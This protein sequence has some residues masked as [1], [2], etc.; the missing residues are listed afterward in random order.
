MI[1]L[2]DLIH[3][4]LNTDIWVNNIWMKFIDLHN[5]KI[6]TFEN[7]LY[8]LQNIYSLIKVFNKFKFYKKKYD[9]KMIPFVKH[10]IKNINNK[11][12]YENNNKV[13]NYRDQ[14]THAFYPSALLLIYKNYNNLINDSLFYNKIIDVYDNYVHKYL[15]KKITL[16]NLNI[17][18]HCHFILSSNEL[19]NYTNDDKYLNMSIK[20]A[21]D[22]INYSININ[23]NEVICYEKNK[24]TSFHYYC[25]V[26]QSF[27]D[28]Y[29]IIYNDKY[30]IFCQKYLNWWIKKQNDDGSFYF[31][32][33][34]NV[35][36]NVINNKTV[37][38]VHQMGM[39]LLG[40]VGINY[41]SNNR[42]YNN[43]KKSIK[44]CQNNN[45]IFTLKYNSKVF[46]RSN[47]DNKVVYS[48]ELGL[49]ILGQSNLLKYLFKNNNRF[50]ITNNTYFSNTINNF[51][52]EFNFN[53]NID[54][55]FNEIDTNF[56][57]IWGKV[58]LNNSILN[59]SIF[60]S[61]FINNNNI[62]E[63]I[64][65]NY[66]II[67]KYK[68]NIYALTDPFSSKSIWYCNFD[69]FYISNSEQNIPIN[70]NTKRLLY[71]SLLIYNIDSSI[72]NIKNNIIRFSLTNN[73]NCF[74]NFEKTLVNNLKNNTSNKNKKYALLLS[75]G[76]DS[77]TLSCLLNNLN[78]KYDIFSLLQNEDEIIIKKRFNLAK[79]SK[80]EL[81]KLSAVNYSNIKNEM[82]NN[83]ENFSYVINNKKK[84]LYDDDGAI[85]MYFICKHISNNYTDLI[86]GIGA[87]EILTNYKLNNIFPSDLNNYFP[88]SNLFDNGNYAFP[89]QFTF[90]CYYF[91]INIL[92]PI[93]N[94]NILQEFLNIN[95][96]LKNSNNKAPLDFIMTKYNYP[97][98]K[99]VKIGFGTNL[100]SK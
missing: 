20:L 91:N 15:D 61:E 52:I 26:S 76:Y 17:Q 79:K 5:K 10:F 54:I 27:I 88:W 78:I 47:R 3:S 42:Y 16:D 68:N 71:N 97:F 86:T 73:I 50:L 100:V 82:L 45:W 94:R 77:G 21:N 99:N 18:A 43:I 35:I 80:S 96:N 40:T 14:I 93:L 19:Y 64:Y 39:F 29:E 1:F 36:N 37:Y 72:I 62:I 49:E 70:F 66:C 28:L 4:I 63:N 55:E 53:K 98:N 84:L 30:L 57:I 22:I 13:N 11:I 81:Y 24:I 69:H 44:Y 46:R 87:D 38:S 90:I 85:G 95:H 56:I 74:D 59:C 48:Y 12:V 41:F 2:E 58:Y 33:K 60:Y 75:S 31:N 83:I 92:F 89:A 51:N 9:K 65:G 67:C 25:Y 23:E 32:Y 6:S 7:N 8:S 34:N